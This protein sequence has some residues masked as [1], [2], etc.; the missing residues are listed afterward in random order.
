M[1]IQDNY[2]LLSTAVQIANSANLSHPARIKSIVRLIKKSL[3][4]HAATIYLLDPDRRSLSRMIAAD[5]PKKTASCL[6]P[7]GEHPAGLCAL[8]KEVIFSQHDPGA[9]NAADAF[10]KLDSLFLPIM[11]GKRVTGILALELSAESP[12]ATSLPMLLR[13]ILHTLAGIICAGEIAHRSDQRIQNLMTLNELGK[14]LQQPIPFTAILPHVLKKA[15]SYSGSSCTIL[16]IFSYGEFTPKVLKACRKQLR[17]HLPTLQEIETQSATRMLDTETPHLTVD[18]IADEDLPP[19]YLTIPLQYEGKVFGCLTFFGKSGQS[20]RRNFDEEDRELFAGMA[21]LIAPALGRSENSRRMDILVTE[22]SNKL[23]ELSL[24]Y[25]VSNAMHATTRINRLIHLNLTALVSGESHLFERAML[26]LVN[27]RS[28]VLQG[29]LGIST[30]ECHGILQSLDNHEDSLYSRWEIS[31]EDM[32]R[33]QNSVFSLKVKGTRLPLD[34]SLNIP[35]RAVLEKKLILFDGSTKQP[36]A[37]DDI[38]KKFTLKSFASVPIIAKNETVAV[39]ILD[40]PFSDK[41]ITTDDLRFLQLFANQAGM[42]IENSMLYNR[43]ED[44]NREFSEIRQRLLQG[45]RLAALGETAASIAHE[46]K[47]PLVAIG[48]LA[49]R[50]L[51]KEEPGSTEWKYADTIAHEAARLEKMLSE[52]LFFTKRA[53]ICYTQCNMRDIIDQSLAV[54]SEFLDENGIQV[55]KRISNASLEFLGDF[56]QIKQVCINL[57]VNAGEA[58]KQGGTLFVSATTTV[59]EGKEAVSLKVRDT[60]GGIFPEILPDIFNPFFTTKEGG[61]GL[62]LPIAHR[63][64][65]NHGGQLLVESRAGSGTEFRIIIPTRP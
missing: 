64:V 24:L 54:V 12:P 55:K 51:R 13:D 63:I 35:S 45:E 17:P 52:I 53:T 11:S 36:P 9:E 60:G 28:G 4:L 14:A 43:L 65:T 47:T 19:S 61:T 46:L 48:G 15:H 57:F 59:A 29:M 1:A 22:N 26:F 27:N 21:N 33:Q 18:L 20:V 6:I 39:V 40:N 42:A 49:R 10:R 32:E 56:Q 38:I 44:A 41:T 34:K 2:T 62:G 31:D 23:K 3:R 50:L 25:R 5:G 58:M 37:K 16:R 30:D 8:K 7:L